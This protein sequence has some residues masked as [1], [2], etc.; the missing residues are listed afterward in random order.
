MAPLHKKCAGGQSILEYLILMVVIMLAILAVRGR[1]STA[2]DNLYNA[3]ANRVD[4]AAT[5][6]TAMP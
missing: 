6:L 2:V 3:S 5:D 1:I 4:K